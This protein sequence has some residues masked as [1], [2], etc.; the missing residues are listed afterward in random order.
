M[1]KFKILR[2]YK[3][4]ATE[5]ELHTEDGDLICYTI[6][7]SKYDP[8]HP[9]IPE[10]T[11]TCERY[12][13]PKHGEVWLLKNVP[14][15]TYIEI[16]VVDTVDYVRPAFL[17]GCIGLGKR[18]G[19]ALGELAVFDAHAAFEEFMALTEDEDEIEI[20]IGT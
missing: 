12:E 5:G 18:R 16:H 20:T 19:A 7:R 11:Y 15:R 2:N 13:S 17:Q 8:V 3:P 9:C 10:G 6:E 4:G 1:M 14:G